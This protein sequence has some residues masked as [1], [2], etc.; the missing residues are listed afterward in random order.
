MA[1]IKIKETN[2]RCIFGH[3]SE[4]K[5]L[6]DG[7]KRFN[8]HPDCRPAETPPIRACTVQIIGPGREWTSGYP[9]KKTAW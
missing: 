1:K 5:R 6:R 4:R 7:S 3:S 2:P 8:I 9:L